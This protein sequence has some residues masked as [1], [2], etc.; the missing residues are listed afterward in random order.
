MKSWHE[1]ANGMTLHLSVECLFHPVAD[2]VVRCN[3][4][5]RRPMQANLKAAVSVF[6]SHGIQPF[7]GQ[8]AGFS[9]AP[10][11]LLAAIKVDY[12]PAAIGQKA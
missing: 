1:P 8:Q 10:R 7:L 9:F 6:R 12:A 2:N 11:C 5:S 3:Q 4:S